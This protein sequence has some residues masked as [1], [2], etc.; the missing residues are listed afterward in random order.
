MDDKYYIYFKILVLIAAS[1]VILILGLRL[2]LG[3]WYA[4]QISHKSDGFKILYIYIKINKIINKILN[5]E[6]K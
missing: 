6:I 4:W 1:Y 5:F 3:Y 2:Y